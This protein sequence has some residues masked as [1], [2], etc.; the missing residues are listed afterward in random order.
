MKYLIIGIFIIIIIIILMF[1]SFVKSLNR[2]KEAFATMDVYFKKRWELIPNIVETVKGYAFYEE[3]T[4]ANI[5]A[6]RSQNYD[7]LNNNE[8]KVN[9]Y[10]MERAITNL[11]AFKEAYPNLKANTGFQKLMKELILI[12]DELLNARKYYNATVR[13]F[14][15]KIMIFPNNLFAKLFNFKAYPMFSITDDEMKNVK[16]DL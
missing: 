5:M 12:E 14:N 15:T 10:E 1:N 9:D 13:I 6:N 3:K 2:V 11:M 16:V 7:S 8:K 4:F